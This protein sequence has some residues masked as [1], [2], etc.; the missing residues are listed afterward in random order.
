M[1]TTATDQL[2]RLEERLEQL[3][4]QVD[5]LQTENARLARSE[6]A[7]CAPRPM[8]RRGLLAAAGGAAAALVVAGNATP[9]AAVQGSAV[10]AGLS[11]TATATTTVITT[12]TRGVVGETSAPTGT[13]VMGKSTN[14]TSGTIGVLGTVA[15]PVGIGVYGQNTATAGAGA[16]MHGITSSTTGKGVWGHAAALSGVCYGVY[17]QAPLTGFALYGVGRLKVTGRAYLGTPNS[18]PVDA[19]LPIPG[20]TFY[21]NEALNQLK[22]R[23]R[24]TG[25]VM[26]TGTIGL[27]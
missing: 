3:S 20:I 4:A 9:A 7:D 5:A 18:A 26:K 10:L 17:G 25:G 11:N 1:D 12:G 19:D 15:A 13:G 16:G 14:T 2:R 21:L 27:L 22:V 23:V 6:P 8:S 24:Y